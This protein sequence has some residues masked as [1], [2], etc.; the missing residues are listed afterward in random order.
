MKDKI[1]KFFAGEG[2]IWAIISVVVFIALV[3]TVY[4]MQYRAHPFTSMTALLFFIL[5]EALIGA[6]AVAM[7]KYIFA[8]IF[9]L[10]SF[11]GFALQCVVSDPF[12]NSAL[13]IAL[14]I[15]FVLLGAIVGYVWT[16]KKR[17]S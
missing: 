9:L 17:P 5:P 14:N 6:A 10:L 13:G 16:Q 8:G 12:G 3:A 4:Y 15:V 2:L 7:R 1:K 11:L